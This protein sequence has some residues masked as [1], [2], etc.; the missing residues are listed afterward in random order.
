MKFIHQRS[1]NIL[2]LVACKNKPRAKRG[3]FLQQLPIKRPTRKFLKALRSNAFK[4]F[5]VTRLI[6]NC[7]ISPMQA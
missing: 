6:G 7:R 2:V 3:L 1:V 4:I 5:S